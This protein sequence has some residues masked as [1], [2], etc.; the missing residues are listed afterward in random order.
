MLSKIQIDSTYEEFQLT[1]D[2][3]RAGN[4]CK[5]QTTHKTQ[6]GGVQSRTP[7]FLLN[8]CL[9]LVKNK[10]NNSLIL[11]YKN[12]SSIGRLEVLIEIWSFLASTVAN[13]HGKILVHGPH[14]KKTVKNHKI[15]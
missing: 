3:P 10:I 4:E 9:G 1:L 7:N 8:K 13:S 5:P 15:C 6:P 14:G 11:N 2:G 12:Y